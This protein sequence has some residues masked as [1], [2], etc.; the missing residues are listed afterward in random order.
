VRLVPNKRFAVL[1]SP[2]SWYWRDLQ[3]AAAGRYDLRCLSF[4]ALRAAL[5][6]SLPHD[7]HAAEH[8][9]AGHD[10]VLVR[11]MP[12]G[13]LE[14]VVFRMN[15]LACAERQGTLVINPARSLEIA[16]DK[17]LTLAR[18][19][20]CGLRVPRTVTCQTWRAAMDGFEALGG[21]VV[22]KPIFGGE[23]RGIARIEDSALA[24]R[25]FKMLEQLG[26]VLYLQQ[27]IPHEGCDLRLLVLG[28]QIWGVRRINPADWRTNVSR[29]ASTEPL[30]L[31]DSLCRLARTAARAVGC[32]L[33]G[34]DLLP[35]RDGNLYV[36]E[37]NAVPG[38]KALAQT[39]GL[40]IAQQLLQWMEYAVD[41]SLR[42]LH[43]ED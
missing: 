30:Q 12:P 20:S 18:L 9:L 4:P 6:G 11:T 7:I 19:A 34:V 42:F 33:A 5:G 14:Q 1:S 37:V 23:G 22:V 16:I 43:P 8:Q 40:D 35:G 2:A 10:A 29:G 15:A 21:H 3:R 17:Y 25:A 39:L 38:W 36:L 27:F 13:S 24:L 32:P 31:D 26:A 41:H 28:E